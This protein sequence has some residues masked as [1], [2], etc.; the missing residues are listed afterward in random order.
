M[1]TFIANLFVKDNKDMNHVRKTYGLVCGIYGISLNICL[2]VGK[3]FAGMISGSIAIMA[4]AINN[5]S[6]AGS[7]FVTLIGFILGGKKAD[8]DHPYGHGRLEYLSAM[9]V[10][11]FILVMGFELFKTSLGR[12]L[13]PVPIEKSMVTWVTLI[14]AIL[15]KIY[16]FCYNRNIGK[17]ID[18]S[19]MKATALDSLSDAV[20]T[21]AVLVSMIICV[22][23]KVNI[24][25]YGGVL[26]AAFIIYTGIT[27]LIDTVSPLLGKAPDKELVARIE[28]VV[29]S[30]DEIL[31]IHDLI[32][33][34]YGPGRVYASLHGEVDG[35]NNLFYIHNVID[36]IENRLRDELGIEAVIHMDPVALDN[37]KMYEI[38]DEITQIVKS[39]DAAF[40]IHDLRVVESDAERKILFDLLTPFDCKI[41]DEKIISDVR[42]SLNN[43]WADYDIVIKIDKG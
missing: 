24:D 3:Y 7:S 10:A 21:F 6:D 43:T 38:K 8:A 22:I 36:K 4:D 26:V 13:N 40:S 30:Y 18:S 25:G 33:H 27:A 32:V 14:V 34:D 19:A 29:E 35:N 1:I 12:I 37:E 42:K 5:L 16:M 11:C 28:E 20:A 41:S 15:V 2:F 9:V 39:I 17:R 23:C 31:G